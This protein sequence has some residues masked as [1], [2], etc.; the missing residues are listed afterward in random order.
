MSMSLRG[1][2]YRSST[3]AILPSRRGRAS[4]WRNSKMAFAIYCPTPGNDSISSLFRGNRPPRD[5]SCDAKSL[6]D[7]ARRRHNPIGRSW[8]P[9]SYSLL[10]ASF[11]QDEKRLVKLGRKAATVS[12]LVRCSNT[13][14]RICSYPVADRFRHGNFRPCIRYHFNNFA[15]NAS[16]CLF[17]IVDCL[18]F[19]FVVT[20]TRMP[21]VSNLLDSLFHC[22]PSNRKTWPFLSSARPNLSSSRIRLPIGNF[23][24]S[25]P[26]TFE[27]SS[28]LTVPS[29][30]SALQ[31]KY[32]G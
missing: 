31:T 26:S 19:K 29:C 13:S 15:R 9:M 1:P 5:A 32:N 14:A 16:S 25:I 28:R 12:A 17:E 3:R 6:S 24:V 11:A 8:R 2:K 21:L 4:P 10:A 23:D 20:Q 18:S 30:W 27:S 22:P 7:L